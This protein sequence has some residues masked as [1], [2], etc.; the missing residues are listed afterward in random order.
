MRSIK[1]GERAALV[2]VVRVWRVGVVGNH[3]GTG[4]GSQVPSVVTAVAGI[5]GY[6]L[7]SYALH[8]LRQCSRC[9]NRLGG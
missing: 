5:A 8:L 7:P 2:G 4:L 6:F 1:A 9:Q 3:L